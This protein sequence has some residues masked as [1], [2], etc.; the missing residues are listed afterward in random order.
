MR[1][2]VTVYR[3]PDNATN[4]NNINNNN[5]NACHHQFAR[6]ALHAPPLPPTTATWNTA[7]P[8]AYSLHGIMPP[9]A[10]AAPTPPQLVVNQQRINECAGI[11]LISNACNHLTPAQRQR[12]LRKS[13]SKAWPATATHAM[14]QL[15][16]HA[17]GQPLLQN[18][19]QQQ[20]QQ[21]LHHH[22][23]QLHQQQQLPQQQQHHQQHLQ[24][25]WPAH[26]NSY[27]PM[28][29]NNF[30]LTDKSRVLR[31]QNSA[32][33]VLSTQEKQQQQQSALSNTH[34]SNHN[35]NNNNNSSSNNPGQDATP[36]TMTESC[37]PR[38]IK[39][40]K[41]RKK[42]RKPANGV[43]LKLDAEMQPKLTPQAA[44]TLPAAVYAAQ[45]TQLLPNCGNNNLQQHDHSHGVCFCRDCDPLRSLW[46]YPLRRSHSDASSQGQSSNSSSRGSCST[47]SSST[48]S[49]SD[50]S[51]ASSICSQQ[52][53]QQLQHQHQHKQHVA[54]SFDETTT[55]EHFA[56]ITGDSSRAEIVG[57]IGSQR[58]HAHVATTTTTTNTAATATALYLSD[59]NDSGYGDILSGM[60]IA[61][62][63][64]ASCFNHVATATSG[65]GGGA[66]RGGNAMDANAETL[67]NESI[68]EI[69][70]KL[71]ETCAVNE[72]TNAGLGD[73]S[74]GS[75]SGSGRGSIA[76]GSGSGS[77]DSDSCSAS[78]S[79]SGLDSAGS[80][81]SEALVF[82]FEHLH[83]TDTN[84]VT[85]TAMDFLVDCNNNNNNNC[86]S[87]NSNSGSS[88]QQ[89]YNNCFDLVWR[90]SSNS[91]NSNNHH[92]GNQVTAGKSS[93]SD[94][95]ATT[96][97][98]LILGTVGKLK[99][100]FSTIS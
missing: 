50:N 69:S 6:Y 57:V 37:L 84:F 18:S 83:L 4:I 25:P 46:D 95:G 14:S 39:P 76:S 97:T 96:P 13:S 45:Q 49:S 82:N 31:Y 33:A 75:G 22:H 38:I 34:S 43:L 99:P 85:P 59:S 78:A 23:H 29:L 91:G 72:P 68:N 60:N 67:L 100:A 56:P 58:S 16:A 41:R 19:K 90:S 21:H 10:A 32:P 71:I 47:S 66:G 86:I 94:S 36:A 35:N 8:T 87:S 73:S 98:T 79:D 48:S 65:G 54:N 11:P 40:R 70:R 20:Q 77:G 30:Q 27:H 80:Y 15:A 89:F 7:A 88:K 9:N 26:A 52:Q 12:M 17:Q 93:N 28:R 61:N 53:Q 51:C 42:D 44:P 63:L 62:D 74:I 81:N 2:H 24:Q 5:S 1:S 64:F 92:S 55:T 3:A